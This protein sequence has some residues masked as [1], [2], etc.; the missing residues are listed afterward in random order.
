MARYLVAGNL[1]STETREIKPFLTH[2]EVEF[3][4]VGP[5]RDIFGL[6][7]RPARE[8]LADLR[9]GQFDLVLAGNMFPPYFNPRKNF[10][11]NVANLVGKLVREPRLILG[12]WLARADFPAPLVGLDFEDSPIID[13][14]RFH[15]LR[16]SVCYFKREL[17]QNPCNAFLYTNAKT[18][19]NG[20][21]LHTAP[22]P[23]WLKKL[24]PISLGIDDATAARL[25]SLEV[26]KETDVFFAG[27]VQNRPN[28]LA[29]LRQ[30]RQLAV[31]GFKIDLPEGR[32]SRDEFLLRCARA[33]LVWS[34]EG[35]GWDCHRHYEIAAAGSVPL[36]QTPT[37]QRYA[38]LADGDHALYYWVE[39]DHLAARVRQ[40]LLNRARLAEMGQAARRH[41]LQWHTHGVQGHY[42]IEESKRALVGQGEV[43]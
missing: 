10:F 21:V 27:D 4:H 34:P 16:R 19:C 40:A 2:S 11:R 23:D 30:L 1:S 42:I 18:E 3:L 5:R 6:Q 35:F 31:A 33:Y 36:M 9:R 38:P 26:K 28:R 17:P 8:I 7:R 24:R 20:N 43:S 25:A 39:G 29:G 12:A 14:A 22:F 32:L 37:I 41:V 15:V 13:N